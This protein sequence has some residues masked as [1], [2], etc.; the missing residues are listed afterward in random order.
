MVF[1]QW[2]T[3]VGMWTDKEENLITRYLFEIIILS[4]LVKMSFGKLK[5][6]K[7]GT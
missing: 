6:K 1:T 4:S 5:L 3:V 7:M 2:F